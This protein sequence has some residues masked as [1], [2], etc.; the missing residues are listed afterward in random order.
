MTDLPKHPETPEPSA[1]LNGT[2]LQD[3]ELGP[4]IWHI[5]LIAI[6]AIAFTAGFMELYGYLNEIL[7]FHNDFVTR[8][9]WTIPAG[10][11]FFSLIV[12][13]CQK[14]LR[15]PTVIT[16]GFVESMKGTG[17]KSDY[18]T[19]PGAFI[20]SLASLL[21]GASIG[22][23]GTIAIM[24][25]DIATGLRDRWKIASRSAD[26]ALG[27]DVAALASAFNGIVGSVIFTGIF[28]TEFQVGGKKNA[29]KFLIWNLL[30]GTIGFLFYSLLGLE[31]FAQLIPFTPISEM[32]LGVI[33][34]AILLGVVG[35][36]L[37]LSAG[38]SMQ[39]SGKIMGEAFG[40]KVILRC[41]AA[42]L[43]IGVVCYFIPALMFS[44]EEQ[45]HTIIAESAQIGIGMLLFMAVLK[46]LLLGL[47]F[48][49]GY[50]GG[51]IFPVLFASTMV[52]L[53]LSLL[54][55]GIPVGVFV[56][57]I[58]AAAISLA[59]GAPLTAILLVAIVGTANSYMITLLVVSS[60]TAMLIAAAFKQRKAKKERNQPI[61]AAAG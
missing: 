48:K 31:A 12:G 16:G 33:V 36:L 10:V 35:S 43:V 42:G 46:I 4:K 14:Y 19:F 18:R 15:A 5:F 40:E 49:S 34:V 57:C 11:L 17:E 38:F 37:A 59:L 56:M 44:G 6:I 24:V 54:F 30:A 45:I 22:P 41:L 61:P 23:E 53:A 3:E 1:G 28:A 39:L 25:E 9:R 8:N 20:S 7:W 58:E 51:P 47:S 29:L 50:I 2:D 13:L 26:T 60:V 27:F 21:S 52:G 32:T 55:P